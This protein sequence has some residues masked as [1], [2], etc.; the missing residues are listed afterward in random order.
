MGTSSYRDFLHAVVMRG[1][2]ESATLEAFLARTAPTALGEEAARA[3]SGRGMVLLRVVSSF[4][5]LDD[6]LRSVSDRQRF[7]DTAVASLGNPDA[8]EGNAS[9]MLDLLTAT[10]TSSASQDFRRT[11]LDH[12]Y[13]RQRT[14]QDAK[15]RSV[16]GSVLS[17]YQTVTGDRRIDQIDRDYPLDD[18]MFRVP[19][20]RLFS[21]DGRGGHIHRMFMRLDQD[22][23]ATVTYASF[24]TLMRA[25]RASI[26][27]ERHFDVYRLTA[28]GRTVEIFANNPT[29][30][31]LDRGIADIAVALRGK[32]VE[33]VIGRG[34]T[35]IVTPLQQNARQILGDGVKDVATVMI[36]TCGGDASVREL[37]AT[38]GY[39][40]FFTTRSTGRQ[41][42]NNAL[43]AA[44]VAALMAL[45]RDGRLHLPDVLERA[46]APFLRK[47]ANEDLRDD[48]GFYRLSMTSV[49]AAYLFDTHVRR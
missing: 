6:V 5:L 19:F 20:A 21:P 13:D 2:A 15:L 4:G 18:A 39:S 8:F 14:E 44:Y 10:S 25:R 31:G 23:D 47:G 24:L 36:G 30:L 32:R 7:V 1:I 37:I 33:T 9:V 48:A 11:L 22:V 28:R 45:P 27:R 43:I 26:R 49:L 16:Y 41:T 29:A 46:K 17:V 40:P 42:I 12:L 3:A 35:S 38:F 34:H